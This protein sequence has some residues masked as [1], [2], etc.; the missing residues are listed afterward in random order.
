MNLQSL[1][2]LPSNVPALSNVLQAIVVSALTTS[3]SGN[4]STSVNYFSKPITVTFT[5]PTAPSTPVAVVFWNPLTKTWQPISNYTV[6][7][8]T[9]TMTTNHFT[10]YAVVNANQVQ[11]VNRIEGKRAIDTAIQA[12][13]SAYPDGASSVVLA[14]E[15]G[16]LP[17]PDALSAAGLAGAVHA[18]LL[19]TG[20]AELDPAVLSAIQAL[21]AKTVYV[22]GGPH[23]ISDNV[24]SALQQA[25]L[26][27]VRDFEGQTLYDTSLLIDQYMYQN[28][29]TNASTVFIANGQTMVDAAS[30]SPVAYQQGAPV[31]LVKT[32]Q[33]ALTSDQLSFLQSAGIKNAVL[34]G[35][36]YVVSPTLESQLDQTLGS[37]NVLRLGGNTLNDTAALISQHYFPNAT[38][39]VIATNGTPS[40]SFV[41]ALSASAFAANNDAPILFT[42]QNALPNSTSTYLTGLKSLHNVWVM[43]G[44]LAVQTSIDQTLAGDIPASK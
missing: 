8:N 13:E 37:T 26:T 3:G 25:G 32:G 24:V 34:F 42:N 39:A 43:G 40:G 16:K 21:G 6:N 27:V 20:Q 36:D 44:P 23:A 22:L 29:L 17:S 35:G 33:T 31:M 4:T 38:G 10:T 18:P 41:D 28:K 30:G 12:A 11:P 1:T 2:N 14:Y 19:L 9:I 15:G 7:Q 5:L